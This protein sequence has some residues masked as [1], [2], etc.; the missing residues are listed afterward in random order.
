M[1]TSTCKKVSKRMTEVEIKVATSQSSWIPGR[2]GGS[3]QAPFFFKSQP[4]SD[5]ELAGFKAGFWWTVS[6]ADFFSK[7]QEFL[8]FG[9]SLKNHNLLSEG[10]KLE[11]LVPLETSF[12][13]L[14]VTKR[15]LF[16]NPSGRHS[17]F[18]SKLITWVIKKDLGWFLANFKI[19]AKFTQF[20]LGF[21]I[22]YST[23]VTIQV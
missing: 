17:N 9:Y 23:R 21:E 2:I 11:I 16:V 13:V 4:K 20:E 18:G 5:Q 15:Y 1:G 10:L 12:K 22:R 6:R 7:G 8:I 19:L 3:D 14:K